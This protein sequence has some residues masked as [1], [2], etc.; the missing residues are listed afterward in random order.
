M[1]ED[2]SLARKLAAA[3]IVAAGVCLVAGVYAFS[4]DN[5]NVTG[6]DF[7]EYWAAEKQLIQGANPY[8]VS[9]IF[10]MEKALGMEDNTPK[11]SMSPPV[12]F[13]FA[14]PLGYMSPKPALILWLLIMLGATGVSAYLLWMIYGR[15]DTR[16]HLL[17]F[18][19]PPTLACL[20]AGQL[21][22]LFLLAFVLFLYLHKSRPWLAGAALLPAALK[23]H[24]FLACIVVLLLWSARRRDFRV[25]VG[26]VIALAASCALTLSL[27]HNI[28]QQY[29]QLMHSAR[30]M[31]VFLP[32]IGVALRFLIDRHAKWIE[33]VPTALGCA[34][35]AWFY[36]AHRDRWNWMNEGLLVLLV[37]VACSPYSWFSDQALLFPAVLAGMFAAENHRLN[38]ILLALIVAASAPGVILGI[39]MPSPFY[40]WTAPAWLAWYLVATRRKHGAG[41]A[42]T[43]MT[44]MAE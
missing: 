42:N 44:A 10:R 12:A 39:Q 33:F 26:F 21:G 13:F 20:M 15:R 43:E 1:P 29:R 6:R 3:L 36:F 30:I 4:I 19:F 40:L 8:D 32:T 22:I 41:V 38:W 11:V 16:L 5:R 9:A 25:V 24:L 27:D 34:W 7:I 31:D 17:A 2:K 37:S 35:A 14:L 28:W 18:A 23:P